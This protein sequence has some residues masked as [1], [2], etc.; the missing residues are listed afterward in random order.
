V[1]MGVASP[2]WMKSIEPAVTST[3][4]RVSGSMKAHVT[5]VNI[6]P[7]NQAKQISETAASN[8]SA[9]SPVQ[10]ISAAGGQK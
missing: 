3:I 1:I 10:K 2:Y 7:I 6:A 8:G 9:A 5:P 4:Q